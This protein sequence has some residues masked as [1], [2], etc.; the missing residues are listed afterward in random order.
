L[1]TGGSKAVK[2]LEK[3]QKTR[4][5]RMIKDYLDQSFLEYQ[6]H[7]LEELSGRENLNNEATEIVKKISAIYESRQKLAHN[8]SIQLVTESLFCQI[9]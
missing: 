7:F 3:E 2:E 4:A 9:R 1:A 8:S 5:N 6:N